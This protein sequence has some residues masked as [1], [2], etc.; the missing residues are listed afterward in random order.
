M[1]K[2]KPTLT[3]EDLDILKDLLEQG[4]PL[5]ESLDL[6]VSYQPNK[7]F[8][9]L[10]ILLLEGMHL[11]EAL[12]HFQIDSLWLEYF[13]FISEF[14]S[15]SEAMQGASAL[16]KTK[17]RFINILKKR[18]T[19]PLCLICAMF[20]FAILT[21]KVILPQ[22]LT[23]L[24][25]FDQNMGMSLGFKL[26]LYLPFIMMF[27]ILCLVLFILDIYNCI[28]QRNFQKLQKKL[29]N[30]YYKT[31]LQYYYSLKFACYYAVLCQYVSGLYDGIKLMYEKMTDSDM[32]VIVY[33]LKQM[34]ENGY[35]FKA[36]IQTM[37]IFHPAFQNHCLLLLSMGKSLSHLTDYISKTEF[38][39]EKRMQYISRILVGTIYG[40]TAMFIIVLYLMIMTPMMNIATAL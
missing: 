5:L 28:S 24:A 11:N 8:G 7:A 36:C 26:V 33:P 21:S 14:S 9:H 37:S 1:K 20:L 15:L 25:S 23:L 31:I 30:K 18:L 35:D 27:V 38:L 29:Q 17:K 34:L 4:Y 13:A 40:V 39:L 6:L 2:S 22:M 3:E 16:L 19:Y 10:K 32:M 12:R